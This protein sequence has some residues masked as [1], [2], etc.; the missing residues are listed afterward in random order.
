MTHQQILDKLAARYL[1]KS[2]DE[3]LAILIFDAMC[4]Y[5]NIDE[6]FPYILPRILLRWNCIL[7]AG[8]DISETYKQKTVLELAILLHKYG[9]ADQ[10]ISEKAVKAIDGLN[11]DVALSDDFFRKSE[12]IKKVIRSAPVS[13]KRKPS[14]PEN[15]TFYR[16]QDV[17]S[18]Q[19]GT[20]FYAAYIHQITGKNESPVVELYDGVF[21]QVPTLKELEKLNAKGRIY[22][23]GSERVSLFAVSGM[24]YLPDLAHQVHL[25]SA[26]VEKSPSNKHLKDPVGLYAGSDL[27][28]LQEDIQEM[29]DPKA[30]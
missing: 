26:C 23:D 19:T 7:N 18:I 9:F 2:M 12:G 14:T 15:I 25:I 17:V 5:K 6:Q 3:D 16:K 1:V 28:R 30:E 27:F 13:L 20:K 10:A 8:K 11:K 29:F 22:N 21:D 24:K 4:D